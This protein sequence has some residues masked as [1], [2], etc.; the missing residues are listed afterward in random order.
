[1]VLISFVTNKEDKV[2][3]IPNLCS[4]LQFGDLKVSRQIAAEHHENL[5]Q[6]LN[7]WRRM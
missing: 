2:G 3:G 1:M 6:F 5:K 7:S 4:V